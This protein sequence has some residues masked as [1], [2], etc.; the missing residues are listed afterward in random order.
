M[1]E[2]DEIM[3]IRVEKSKAKAFRDMLKL[4]NFV[5][6]ETPEERFERYLSTSPRD[7]AI[8]DEDIMGIIK[9]Q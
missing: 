5:K 7:V 4:F 8:T 2:M 6:L 9:G 1:K 3:T